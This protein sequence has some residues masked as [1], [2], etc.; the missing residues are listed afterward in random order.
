VTLRLGEHRGEG[1]QVAG[2]EDWDPFCSAVYTLSKAF[3]IFEI[4]ND[5]LVLKIVIKA[6]SFESCKT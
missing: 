4:H 2:G 1:A 6:F 5:T 3:S